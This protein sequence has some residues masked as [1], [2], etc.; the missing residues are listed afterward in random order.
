VSLT[1][2]R[3][4]NEA[5]KLGVNLSPAEG[6]EYDSLVSRLVKPGDEAQI[7]ATLDTEIAR[8]VSTR[9]APGRFIYGVDNIGDGRDNARE[10][11]EEVLDG[12]YYAARGLLALER[13]NARAR[14]DT[15]ADDS[16]AEV[17]E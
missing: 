15:L 3:E 11:L 8:R 10:A 9:V 5:R 12:L 17:G 1:R 16:V 14:L 4:L 7:L 2:L 13:I 6:R